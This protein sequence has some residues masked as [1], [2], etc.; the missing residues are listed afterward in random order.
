MKLSAGGHLSYYLPGRKSPLEVRLKE[1]VLLAD[2]LTGL[3]M[4]LAEVYLAA[5]N[6]R[7]VDLYSAVVDEKDE[8]Q[9]ISAVDGG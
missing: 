7:L 1:P 8:V 5:V 3:D 6:G 4:P 2:I 9:I